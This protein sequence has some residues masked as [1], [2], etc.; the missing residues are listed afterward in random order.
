MGVIKAGHGVVIWCGDK[1]KRKGGT[2][3]EPPETK[4]N[5]KGGK[6]CIWIKGRFGSDLL[7]R[8]LSRSTIGAVKFHVRVRDGIGWSQY[9]I[10]AEP[11]F[12]P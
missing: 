3:E 9:A 12:Y 6:E 2:G 11:S 5:K 4:Q 10:A 8:G 1:I 7:F